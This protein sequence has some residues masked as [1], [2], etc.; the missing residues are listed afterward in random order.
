[1]FQWKRN[2]QYYRDVLKT[3]DL[4]CR[5]DYLYSCRKL[6]QFSSFLSSQ[7]LRNEEQV[8]IIQASTVLSLAEK[9]NC[10]LAVLTWYLKP[11]LTHFLPCYCHQ[12]C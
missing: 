9:V 4:V 3:V 7:N 6:L 11:H 10:V 12:Y 5:L 1:M 2:T 8:A